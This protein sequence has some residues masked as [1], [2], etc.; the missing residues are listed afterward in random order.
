MNTTDT[1]AAAPF[2]VDAIY[3]PPIEGIY[4]EVEM[5]D[6]EHA[7]IRDLSGFVSRPVEIGQELIDPYGYAIPLSGLT[8]T[9]SPEAA[10]QYCAFTHRNA[11]LPNY[12]G[13]TSI[14]TEETHW[15]AAV[16]NLKRLQ[17]DTW[18]EFVPVGI[19][20]RFP[21]VVEDSVYKLHNGTYYPVDMPD[22][23]V[24]IC[25]RNMGHDGMRFVFDFGDVNT[26]K[27]WN[28]EFN[29]AGHIGR[30]TGTVKIPLLVYNRRA[31]GGPALLGCIVRVLT[32]R[33]K[34]VLYQ[35]PNYHSD[36]PAKFI[37]TT[38]HDNGTRRIQVTATDEDAARTMVCA[39]E[40]C[41]PSAIIRVKRLS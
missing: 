29:T 28:E 10:P 41:P 4:Y 13:V 7:A 27:S 40:G 21:I 11:G 39:V 24:D 35:H 9:T 6:A 8:Y 18:R 26:G 22:E 31:Y 17:P 36:K 38:R 32:A 34:N 37:V 1:T 16:E 20:S 30:S 3:N 25:A 12:S 33:G 5:I 15:R 14:T 19:V 2:R 23:V